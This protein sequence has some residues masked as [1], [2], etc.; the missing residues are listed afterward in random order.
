MIVI[1]IK[2]IKIIIYAMD[3]EIFTWKTSTLTIVIKNH[4]V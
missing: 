2:V 1:I 3:I 4:V